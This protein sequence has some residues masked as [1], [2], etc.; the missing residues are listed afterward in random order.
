[1][2]AP[3]SGQN[4]AFV[5]LIDAAGNADPATAVKATLHHDAVPPASSAS[6]PATTGIAPIR[7][8]WVAS[9]TVSGV[10]SVAL[11]VKVG[12]GGTWTESG[13][14]SRAD[15]QGLFLYPPAGE[16]TYSFA[17]RAVDRA[18][19]AEAEPGGEGDAQSYCETWQRAYLPL[20]WKD[21]P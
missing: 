14:W 2:T 1:V 9:D 12:E 19:N 6:A 20:V 3:D 10:E 8:M 21:S 16:G 13:L 5:W 11:W 18:G 7:V 17:T 15:G 4:D